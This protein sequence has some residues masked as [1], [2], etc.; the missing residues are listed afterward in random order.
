MNE[1][2]RS[3]AIP[4]V[5][6]FAAAVSIIVALRRGVFPFFWISRSTQ[7]LR[8][9]LGIALTLVVGAGCLAWTISIVEYDLS[10]M[11]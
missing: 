8:F 5:I 1:S 9:W 11:L 3:Q 6:A 10:T 2:H 7:P 4:P